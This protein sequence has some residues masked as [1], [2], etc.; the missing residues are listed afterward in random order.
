MFTPSRLTLARRRRG[1][2]LVA[3]SNAID[4]KVKPRTISAYECGD[5][6]PTEETVQE[7]A[8][9]LRFP[10]EFFDAP[11][12]VDASVNGVSFRALTRM[13]ASQRDAAIAAG[14]LVVALNEWLSERFSLP[15]EDIAEVLPAMI[16]P[17]AAAKLVRAHWGLG[18]QP[19]GNL[20]YL[21]EAH[22]V[23]VFSLTED[24]EEVDAF[25]FWHHGT[26][27]M[28][29]NTRKTAEHSRF[30]AAHE[31]GHLVMHRYGGSP[32]GRQEELEAN[33]F[34]SAFLMPREDVLASAPRFPS[35]ESLV[36]AKKRW[37]VSVAALNYRLHQIDAI[38]EWHYRELCIDISK[39]GRKR[40]PNPSPREHSQV[41]AKAFNMLR[42]DGVSRADVAR[43]LC[44]H[45]EDLEALMF[46]LVTSGIDGGQEAES[47][48]RGRL[49][50]VEPSHQ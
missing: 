47:E 41:L 46:R 12:L 4:R 31:L 26:P 42:H 24:C 1:M 43:E 39:Y 49:R 14:T 44:L 29:L 7:F 8:R 33:R 35:F 28:C 45:L 10:R 30:D 16:E 37:N 17:N 13:T 11:E 21:L 20:I 2:T 25:S 34:A 6:A 19:I 48:P 32:R 27:F 50:L 9:V 23:R 15:T 36:I 18:E 5:N 22:G 40:E 3:L 38:S